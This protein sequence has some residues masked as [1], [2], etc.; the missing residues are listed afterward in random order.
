MPSL[1][2]RFGVTAFLVISTLGVLLG[3]QLETVISNRARGNA[4][5]SALV[6]LQLVKG[7]FLQPS[8]AGSVT[9]APVVANPQQQSLSAQILS[10]PVVA[11]QVLSATAW[12]PDGTVAFSTVAD[13]IGKRDALPDSVVK[14][15]SGQ[16]VTSLA[17]PERVT[18]DGY[19]PAAHA[20]E[21]VMVVDMPL[22]IVGDDRPELV[23]ELITD[24]TATDAA[25]RHDTGLVF[26]SLGVGLLLLFVTLFRTVA[27]ASRR[28]RS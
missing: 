12:T 28:L 6:Y 24:F 23:I 18:S 19:D 9:D 5:T 16:V 14:A 21:R 8:V 13:A 11:A 1:I 22:S 27:T 15:F 25:I 17:G 4:E 10:D 26:G 7:S 3:F 20:G 2:V